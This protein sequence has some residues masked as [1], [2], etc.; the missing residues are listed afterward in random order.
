GVT[1][2]LATSAARS[3]ASRLAYSEIFIVK[4]RSTD[5]ARFLESRPLWSMDI[6]LDFRCHLGRQPRPVFE[7]RDL[8]LRPLPEP[9]GISQPLAREKAHRQQVGVQRMRMRDDHRED[10]GTLGYGVTRPGGQ[11]LGQQ[12]ALYLGQRSALEHGND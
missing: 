7:A 8:E 1:W 12:D 5:A 10:P 3:N 11:H 2:R 4:T 6:P 9:L